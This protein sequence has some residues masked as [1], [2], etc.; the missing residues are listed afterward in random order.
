MTVNFKKLTQTI[1]SVKIQNAVCY[2]YSSS[3]G[4]CDHSA[5][6]CMAIYNQ[7]QR[8]QNSKIQT[9]LNVVIHTS[10]NLL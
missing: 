10:P 8:V 2:T 7:L 4:E 9:C 3:T 5:V 6:R 1:R